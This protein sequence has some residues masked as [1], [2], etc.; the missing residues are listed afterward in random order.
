[1]AKDRIGEALRRVYQI[2]ESKNKVHILQ[3]KEITRS[4]REILTKNNWL[5]E[6]MRGWYLLVRPDINSGESSAWYA[7]FWDF[8]KLYLEHNYGEEYCLSADDSLNLHLD[9]TTV[10]KQVVVIAKAGASAPIKL[11]FKTSLLIYSGKEIIPEKKEGVQKLNMM[12]LPY[13]LC[14]VSPS[15]FIKN[16]V[17]AEIALRSIT[18]P[19]ELIHTIIKYNLVRAAGRIIGAYTFLGN[20]EM[21]W[22]VELAV[23]DAGIPLLKQNPFE[24]EKPLLSNSPFKSPCQTRIELMWSSYREKIIH[25]VPDP[26]GLPKN[27]KEYLKDVEAMHKHDAYHSL[28]IE[29]YYVSKEL[30]EKVEQG[31]WNPDENIIDKNALAARGYY[32]A[33]LEVEKS[34]AEVI[35]GKQPGKIVKKDL[36]NW[37]RKLFSPFVEAGIIPQEDLWGYRRH[38]VYIRNSRH[39]PF[40]KEKLLDAMDGLYQCLINEENSAIRA[41]LGHFLF[42]YIHP[43]MDGNGRISRFLMNVMLASG[44]YPWTVIKVDDRNEY[45]AALEL[46]SASNDIEP[47]AKFIISN[48]K[49]R[50]LF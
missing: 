37:F 6:I 47:F 13:A 9:K 29:G 20:E 35:K 10:P 7:S 8:I 17:D 32:K 40:S 50:K 27:T 1:M 2:I 22:A 3:T 33:F 49:K 26:P 44:G 19:S 24:Q 15:Y 39:A 48:M 42:V 25:L 43:Y 45:F 46:A 12:S 23:S 21:A 5:Q 38:Q 31:N 36:Q 18:D 28:S 11:P 34:I 41:I 4:D 14:K 30:I 16:Q